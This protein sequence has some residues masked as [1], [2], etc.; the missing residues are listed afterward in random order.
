VGVFKID[1]K[2]HGR[3]KVWVP[4]N[5]G[6]API[7]ETGGRL[8]LSLTTTRKRGWG[9]ILSHVGKSSAL[10]SRPVRTS[11]RTGAVIKQRETYLKVNL[12]T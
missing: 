12:D 7:G 2:S 3:G 8:S 5:I 10:R 1:A 4:Q 9:R 6:L 11:H